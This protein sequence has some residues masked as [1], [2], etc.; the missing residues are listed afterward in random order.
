MLDFHFLRIM[1]ESKDDLNNKQSGIDYEYRQLR[2]IIGGTLSPEINF[3][4][5]SNVANPSK[6]SAI[7]KSIIFKSISSFTGE[8]NDEDGF[9]EPYAEL[10]NEPKKLAVLICRY[11]YVSPRTY[12]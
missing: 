9:I 2:K 4:V 3:G 8:T 12:I 10:K 6:I 7:V 1:Q 11:T 5:G